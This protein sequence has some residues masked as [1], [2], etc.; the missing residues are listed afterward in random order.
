MVWSGL[1]IEGEF[2][3]VLTDLTLVRGSSPSLAVFGK[4]WC[5]N[6]EGCR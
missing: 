1:L 4:V 3:L 6:I 2:R 5:K